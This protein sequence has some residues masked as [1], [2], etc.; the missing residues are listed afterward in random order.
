MANAFYFSETEIVAFTLIL[1]RVAAFVAVWPVFGTPSVPPPVKMLMALAIAML[2]LPVINWREN[3]VELLSQ[4]IAWL[5]L[6][7]AVVGL[8]LG[9]V[10]RLYFFA[11]SIGGQ[12]VSVSMGLANAQIMNPTLGARGSAVEQFQVVL[13]T[14]VFLAIDGHHMFIHGLVQ[15]FEF[16]PMH[17]ASIRFDTFILVG[18]AVQEVIVI[19]IKISAPILIAILFVNISM[20]VIG[21]AVPQINVLVT[22]LPVNILVGLAVLTISVPLYITEMDGLVVVMAERLFSFMKGL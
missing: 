11:V 12:I 15:S 2:L 20:G 1:L 21:R 9:F 7:E 6:K 13:A 10:C 22:S 18:N 19:G 14:L 4:H 3:Q 16:V 17:L 8:I 5:A